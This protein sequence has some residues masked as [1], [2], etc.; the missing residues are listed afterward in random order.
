MTSIPLIRTTI[1]ERPA[2]GIEQLAALQ[3][4]LP[5]CG[6]HLGAHSNMVRNSGADFVEG[7]CGDETHGRVGIKLR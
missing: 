4:R 5:V 6:C 2:P 3:V 1:R 7:E